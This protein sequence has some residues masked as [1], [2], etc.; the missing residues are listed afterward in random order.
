MWAAE[1]D[2]NKNIVQLLMKNG[3]DITLLDN[4]RVFLEIFFFLRCEPGNLADNCLIIAKVKFII[5]FVDEFVD[6]S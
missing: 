6:N 3:A 4:V 5:V 1:Y 2:C